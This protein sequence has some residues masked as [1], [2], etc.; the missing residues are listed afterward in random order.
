MKSSSF[1]ALA[2]VVALARLPA[3][4]EGARKA[5][6]DPSPARRRN[7][8]PFIVTLVYT[9]AG[10]FLSV[11]G[12]VGRLGPQLGRGGPARTHSQ[13]QDTRPFCMLACVRACNTRA[14]VIVH[15]NKGLS[16]FLSSCMQC[17]LHSTREGL[18]G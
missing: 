7:V 3:M 18:V 10:W 15:N 11:G 14:R 8:S 9:V 2:T 12:S 4:A 1:S 13:E 5:E 16:F 17:I 6:V